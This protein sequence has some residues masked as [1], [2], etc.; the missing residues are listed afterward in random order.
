AELLE[1]AF[2]LPDLRTVFQR[3]RR[4]SELLSD[5]LDPI[6]GRLLGRIDEA[7]DCRGVLE[8]LLTHHESSLARESGAAHVRLSNTTDDLA[9]ECGLARPGIALHLEDVR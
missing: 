1:F 5:L 7:V 9:Q 4:I 8:A 3:V 6:L 2:Q